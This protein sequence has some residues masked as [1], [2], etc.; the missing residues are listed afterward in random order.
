MT[1]SAMTGTTRAEA[2]FDHQSLAW[3]A[4]RHAHNAE[5]RGR[6]PVVWNPQYRG[7][8]FVSGY[9]EVAAVAR[10]STTF[11]PRYEKDEQG[12]ITHIGIMGIPRAADIPPI[13][14]AEAEGARHAALRR[15]LNPFMLPPAVERFTPFVEQTARWLLDQKVPDGRM[16]MV[17]DYTNPVPAVLTMRM[18]G[19]PHDSW[20]H[21][22]EV[23]HGTA[24]YNMSM[25]EFRA[26]AS[27]IPGMVAEL[28]EIVER[29]R[30]DPGDDLLSQLVALEVEG[31][32]LATDGVVSVVWN[33]I[34]G[35]LD[36]TTSLTSLALHHLALHPQIRQRLIDDPALI[37]GACEEYLR[38]TSVNETLTRTCT[39]DTELAG[40]QI[41]RGDFVMMSW[42]GANFDPAVFDRPDEVIIDRA[43]N[44]HIAFGIGTH[45]CIGMHVARALFE[46]MVREVLARIPDYE[47]EPDQTQ[48]YQGNP[49]LYGV[50]KMPVRF[51][52][53]EPVGIPR[54]W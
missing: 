7:F 43:P 19:L 15:V 38:W 20:P 50:V 49:E 36:T 30:H 42:L 13:G 3:L 17:L 18:L 24:A 8:W 47:V 10:D 16:D 11:T 46:V 48:F 40:Q 22:A 54:P 4:D 23:F 33:L 5:L 26:A 37:P 2:E 25:P 1:E 6:C 35:G 45:R 9:D 44:R 41:T 32:P 12:N 31:E 21:Y 29:R 52:A 28:T 27:L 34:G 51:S 39:A 53:G 14:I